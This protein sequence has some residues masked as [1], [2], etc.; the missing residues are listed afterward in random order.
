MNIN[1]VIGVMLC[2]PEYPGTALRVSYPDRRIPVLHRDFDGLHFSGLESS[3]KKQLVA[4]SMR[5]KDY[6]YSLFAFIPFKLVLSSECN[7]LYDDIDAS[8]PI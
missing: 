3:G 7:S 1:T 5:R 8:D 2:L 4:N 6:P